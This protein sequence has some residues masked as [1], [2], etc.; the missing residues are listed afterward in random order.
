V[1]QQGIVAYLEG[2][3]GTA[4]VWFHV[5][6]RL[7]PT[8]G[9]THYW[10]GLANQYT[11]ANPAQALTHY[12]LA[13]AAL[14]QTGSPQLLADIWQERGRVSAQMGDWLGAADAFAQAAV[15]FP[16]NPDYAAQLEQINQLL[17][18]LNPEP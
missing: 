12:D 4:I 15:L 17:R 13:L 7:A 9:L 11:Q 14:H 5:A 8:D 18:Q 1:R 2:E 6:L 3:W 10:L 16:Q